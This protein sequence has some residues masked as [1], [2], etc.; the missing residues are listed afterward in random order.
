MQ[1][2]F[3]MAPSVLCDRR[4]DFFRR[5]LIASAALL[6]TPASAGAQ[7]H[8]QALPD[9][10]GTADSSSSDADA[11]LQW[12]VLPETGTT[13]PRGADALQWQ[14]LPEGES[15]TGGT[16]AA[17]HALQWVV[18]EPG[19]SE[20]LEQTFTNGLAVAPIS[21][22]PE[23]MARARFRG[24]KPLPFHSVSRN[25]TYGETLYPEMGFWI[26]SVFR[27]S[28]DYRFTFTYQLLGNPTNGNAPD[29]CNWEDFWNK[30]SDGQYLAEVTPLIWGPLSVGVN[31]SQQESFV[32]N[33]ADGSFEQGGQAVGFQVKSNLSTNIGA[34]VVGLNL[35]NPYGKGGPNGTYPAPGEEIQADLGR[36]YLFMGSAA[37]DLGFWFGSDTP[38]VLAVTAGIGNG[39][40]KSIYDTQKFWVNYGP[41]SPIGVVA[42]AFNEHV[43]V[44][45]EHQGQYNGFGVSYKP[46]KKVPLTGTLMFRDFQGTYT[47]VVNCQ[48][49]NPD[50]CRT[51]VDGRI[52]FSF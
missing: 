46:F 16:S 36:T 22:T 48:G 51:T 31:Y 10:I 32:G 38:A 2:V 14:A 20:R 9:A 33:R 29:W 42:L 13:D 23:Q 28:E 43:S 24:P 35:W 19:Q 8:W 21:L 1:H 26:P 47:G 6:S 25:I 18:L 34:G 3:A 4:H 17:V 12:R 37:W 50:N 27:Q 40:Y 52:T 30:C 49:G 45:A 39:R 7:V 11:T 44:F 41:Y 15:A 5:L